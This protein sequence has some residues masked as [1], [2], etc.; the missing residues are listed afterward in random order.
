M[1]S[2]PVEPEVLEV[3][4]VASPMSTPQDASPTPIEPATPSFS[5][6]FASST[7][8]T[9]VASGL[10]TPVRRG[11]SRVH[12]VKPGLS[13]RGRAPSGMPRGISPRDQA[14]YKRYMLLYDT[15]TQYKVAFSHSFA[16]SH[17]IRLIICSI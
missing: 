9:S 2:E 8:P 11:G 10:G 16:L 15:V 7:S 5:N 1:T 12:G 6:T 13:R 3:L 4:E 14:K 17:F